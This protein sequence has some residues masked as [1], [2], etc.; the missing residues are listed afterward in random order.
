MGGIYQI[1]NAHNEIIFSGQLAAV[2]VRLSNTLA[3]QIARVYRSIDDGLTYS[4]LTTC[5]VGVLGDCSFTTDRLSLFAF[6]V[7]VDITPEQFVF[8]T[9]ANQELSTAV[10]S[11]SIIVTGITTP[12]LLSVV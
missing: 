4:Q 11:N 10:L 1:G 5:A 2:T 3:G 12:T 7:P 8:T 9:I 6:A